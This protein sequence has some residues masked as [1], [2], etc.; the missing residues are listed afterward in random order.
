[1]KGLKALGSDATRTGGGGG[2][3][4]ERV[5]GAEGE[6]GG[7]EGGRKRRSWTKEKGNGNRLVA[8]QLS[9]GIG[10]HTAFAIGKADQQRFGRI[11]QR[12]PV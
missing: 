2:T 12:R 9:L 11:H 7:R 10:P 3:R 8:W 6:E 5:K 1:M 4:R